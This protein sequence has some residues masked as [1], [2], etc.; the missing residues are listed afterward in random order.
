MLRVMDEAKLAA[1]I[2]KAERA[3][4]ARVSFNDW[5]RNEPPAHRSEALAFLQFL[6]FGLMP[7]LEHMVFRPPCKTHATLNFDCETHSR[8]TWTA[9][10]NESNVYGIPPSVPPATD[11]WRFSKLPHLELVDFGSPIDISTWFPFRF[12]GPTCQIT[13]LTIHGTVRIAH[14]PD[15]LR[16]G[17]MSWPAEPPLANITDLRI[18]NGHDDYNDKLVAMF[19]PK[20]LQIVLGKRTALGH[21]PHNFIFEPGTWCPGTVGDAAWVFG[22]VGPYPLPSPSRG[23]AHQR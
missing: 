20:R 4:G 13:T 16:D 14:T 7:N 1:T 22:D 17:R 12:P 21:Y 6:L 3:L 19:N 18:I 15:I 9:L 2:D 10:W 8:R 23:A 11:V 5:H